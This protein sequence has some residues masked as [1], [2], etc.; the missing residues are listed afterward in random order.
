M[1]AEELAVSNQT[2]SNE[3]TA[4][5]V[6]SAEITNMINLNATAEDELNL[7]NEAD[8]VSMT[9]E[10]FS[11]LLGTD[12]TTE[13]YLTDTEMEI[14]EIFSSKTNESRDAWRHQKDTFIENLNST[15]FNFTWEYETNETIKSNYSAIAETLDSIADYPIIGVVDSAAIVAGVCLI[16]AV[17]GYFSCVGYRRYLQ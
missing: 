17:F 8:N 6:T 16:T 7:Y 12:E 13:T 4:I 5:N 11:T 3:K 2:D 1:D 10:R 15:L 14:R 9:I